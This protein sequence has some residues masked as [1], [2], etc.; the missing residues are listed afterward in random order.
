MFSN[1]LIL[2]YV[3]Q[4]LIKFKILVRQLIEGSAYLKTVVIVHNKIFLTWQSTFFMPE[5]NEV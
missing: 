1:T 3:P 2:D 5:N 4:Q